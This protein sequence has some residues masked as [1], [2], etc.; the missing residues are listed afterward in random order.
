MYK[1]VKRAVKYIHSKKII[2]NTVE[3]KKSS[4]EKK[5]WLLKINNSGKKYVKVTILELLR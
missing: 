2:N 3:K 4:Q 1:V 5:T